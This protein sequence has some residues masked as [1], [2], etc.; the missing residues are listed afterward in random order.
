MS[1]TLE[2]CLRVVR[3]G[4]HLLPAIEGTR[5]QGMILR[6]SLR[7]PIDSETKHEVL[8]AQH[9]SHVSKSYSTRPFAHTSESE[10]RYRIGH[11]FKQLSMFFHHDPDYKPS[12]KHRRGKLPRGV[13]RVFLPQPRIGTALDT[14]NRHFWRSKCL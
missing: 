11:T 2:R 14:Q 9:T 7:V 10:C 4:I 1:M 6:Q 8:L 5:I 3:G 12:S 13:V